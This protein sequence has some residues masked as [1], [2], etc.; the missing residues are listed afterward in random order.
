MSEV[1]A[2]AWVYVDVSVCGLLSERWFQTSSFE[3]ETMSLRLLA[4]P[5][6]HAACAQLLSTQQPCWTRVTR[7]SLW[8]A[9]TA[10]MICFKRAQTNV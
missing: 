1:R 10:W 7:T 4:V 6:F 5:R 2:A 9:S 8:M 3:P